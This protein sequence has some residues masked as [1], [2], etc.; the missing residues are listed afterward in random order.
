[1]KTF[2]LTF[3]I[4][5]FLFADANGQTA[6]DISVGFPVPAGLN[7]HRNEVFMG[8]SEHK[9]YNPI[10]VGISHEVLPGF[11]ATVD[12]SWYEYLNNFDLT[13]D[14]SPASMDKHF[15]IYMNGGIDRSQLAVMIGGRWELDKNGIIGIKAALGMGHFMKYNF[16][17][18]RLRTIYS[19]TGSP[20]AGFTLT[21]DFYFD[22]DYGYANNFMAEVGLR[23]STPSSY[24]LGAFI[25]CNYTYNQA[26]WYS[27]RLSE[28]SGDRTFLE[29]PYF[30]NNMFVVKA[31]LTFRL[32][33]AGPEEVPHEE[34]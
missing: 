3:L 23:L 12:L 27:S 28:P 1:M 8:D 4:S 22:G 19:E 20:P 9:I 29:T 34:E 17:N 2:L 6:I 24:N 25:E 11:F 21:K 7:L 16:R 26:L 14:P 18:L 13:I 15:L 31:G 5:M 10:N 33:K 32:Y 30:S